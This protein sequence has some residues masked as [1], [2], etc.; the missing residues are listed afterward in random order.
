MRSQS[1]LIGVVLLVGL[2]V[3][4]GGVVAISVSSVEPPSGI[5]D[6]I[7]EHGPSPFSSERVGG[8]FTGRAVEVSMYDPTSGGVVDGSPNETVGSPPP[9]VDDPVSKEVSALEGSSPLPDGNG[10]GV[11]RVS[12][13]DYYV[14][15][16]NYVYTRWDDKRVVFDTSD[17]AVRIGL[18]GDGFFNTGR[19]LAENTEFA[20]DGSHPVEVYIER[21]TS[22]DLSLEDVEFDVQRTDAFRVYAQSDEGWSDSNVDIEDSEF[23][24]IVYAPGSRV[25]IKDSEFYGASVAENTVLEGSS[26]YHDRS[27]SRLGTDALP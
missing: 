13:G 2:T 18:D 26:Y 15:S 8:S 11:V 9:S 6:A 16:S 25:E 23:R 10:G 5:E 3:L 21:S 19:I 7:P 4:L 17:G 22:V 27:L 24:G 12:S 14:N 1:T 20:V